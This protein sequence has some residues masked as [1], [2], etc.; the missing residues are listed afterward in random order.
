[1]KEQNKKNKEKAIN[2]ELLA[3]FLFLLN[4]VN[5]NKFKILMQEYKKHRDNLKDKVNKIYIKY[6]KDGE[7]NISSTQLNLEM[8]KLQKY[9]KEI[10]KQLYEKEDETLIYLLTLILTDSYNKTYNIINKGST[11]NLYNIDK[12]YID[13]VIINYK[14]KNDNKTIRDRNKQN[15]EKILNML[16]RDINNNLKTNKS[17]D[18][19]NKDIDK[20][21]GYGAYLTTRILENETDRIFND[22]LLKVARDSKI[23]RVR[24]NSSLEKNTCNVCENLHGIIFNIDEAP[25]LPLHIKCKCWHEIVLD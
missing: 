19:I 23:I 8:K 6:T 3:L 20:V 25:T 4:Y 1:M 15:K 14:Y 2:K 5:N 16:N 18:K 10:S 22:G 17:I 12:G 9:L 21:M 13:K 7:I 11:E 24:Y